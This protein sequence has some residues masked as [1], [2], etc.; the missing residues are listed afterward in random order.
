[1]LGLFI[2][3]P[4]ILLLIAIPIIVTTKTINGLT[5]AKK[6]NTDLVKKSNTDTNDILILTFGPLLTIFV[7]NQMFKISDNPWTE[8][9]VNN[10]LHAPIW[11]D[12]IPTF[13]TLILLSL[14]GYFVL[15][16][17]PF[18]KLPLKC[19]QLSL[20]LLLTH[21]VYQPMFSCVLC[22][23][24][25]LLFVCALS[26]RRFIHGISSNIRLLIRSLGEQN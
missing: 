4:L 19:L 13:V 21:W 5:S 14:V 16:F 25:M 6:L 26:L 24:I 15:N 20:M 11:P 18:K 22:L 23:G 17:I 2:V 10:A 12:A 3:L 8:V 7:G 1:M 9:N